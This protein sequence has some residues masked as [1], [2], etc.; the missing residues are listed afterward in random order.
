MHQLQ[1][2]EPD[3]DRCQAGGACKEMFHVKRALSSGSSEIAA[4]KE[5]LEENTLLTK[6]IAHNTAGFMAFADDLY[7]GA[8]LLCRCA[9]GVQ[10]ILTEVIKP[11]WLPTLA[12]G[13][14]I[15]WATNDHTLPEWAIKLMTK[16]ILG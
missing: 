16:A 8:R 13:L 6:Q 11:F 15:Y 12:T 9:K 3:I 14:A 7:S 5:Q 1:E 10:F 4:I 2:K